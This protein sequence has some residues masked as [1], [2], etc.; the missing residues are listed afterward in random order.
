MNF[1]LHKSEY[2]LQGLHT[3]E[4]I[5]LYGVSCKLILTTKI[6]IDSTFGD[7]SHIKTDGKN[8][9]EIYAYP[10]NLEEFD[11]YERL[12][13]QF[14]IPYDTSIGLFVS[15][16]SLYELAQRSQ[17]SQNEYDVTIPD[18]RIQ[19]LIGSILVMPS[20]KVLELVELYTDAPGVNN[21]FLYNNLKNVYKIRCKTYVFKQADEIDSDMIVRSPELLDKQPLNSDGFDVIGK[22]FDELT[23]IKR[24]Q[25][26]S[27]QDY[28]E[29]TDDVF[30][31]F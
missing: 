24:R 10:E 29:N 13:S 12:Q 11:P 1:N 2:D 21:T 18:Q 3:E 20:G 14:G 16:I 30:G 22:Y 8:C 7:F 9:F 25:D 15:K 17:N 19:E 23:N 31:R 26:T 4:F 27:T 28:F 6:N 5:R